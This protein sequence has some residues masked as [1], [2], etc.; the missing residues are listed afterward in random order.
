MV[1]TMKTNKG[2]PKALK[3][4][5][6]ISRIPKNYVSKTNTERM[7]YSNKFLERLQ[8]IKHRIAPSSFSDCH[9]TK[10]LISTIFLT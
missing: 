9:E 10:Q 4:L 5:I 6:T 2:N 1:R 7:S 8:R 3:V